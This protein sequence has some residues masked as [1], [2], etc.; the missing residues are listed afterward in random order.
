MALNSQI[1][2]NFPWLLEAIAELPDVASHLLE[3]QAEPH[4]TQ[5]TVTGHLRAPGA[6]FL[7]QTCGFLKIGNFSLQAVNFVAETTRFCTSF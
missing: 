2:V 6:G 7:H 4:V 3:E 5:K 1:T